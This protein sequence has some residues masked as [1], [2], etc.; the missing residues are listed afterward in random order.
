MKK[1]TPAEQKRIDRLIKSEFE[2][3]NGP[4][5][6]GMTTKEVFQILAEKYEEKEA[7]HAVMN[8]A[9]GTSPSEI[10]KADHDSDWAFFWGIGAALNRDL[11]IEWVKKRLQKAIEQNDLKFFVRLGNALKRK[12]RNLAFDKVAFYLAMWWAIPFGKI[13][14]LNWFTDE[15]LVEMLKIL[16]GNEGLT[17]DLVRKARQRLGLQSKDVQIKGVERVGKKGEGFRF[18]WVDKAEK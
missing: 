6:E 10:K 11:K 12:P 3:V 18:I 15:A 13:P 14:P 9:V 5:P 7:F 16:T 8:K 4:W 17:F 1:P 2:K